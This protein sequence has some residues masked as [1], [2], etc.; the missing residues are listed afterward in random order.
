MGSGPQ[1]KPFRTVF[2][3]AGLLVSQQRLVTTINIL[4]NRLRLCAYENAAAFCY[5]KPDLRL[6]NLVADAVDM[7]KINKGIFAGVRGYIQH[8]RVAKK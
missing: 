2:F 1:R 8:C 3:F 7:V 6:Q 5:I 4:C